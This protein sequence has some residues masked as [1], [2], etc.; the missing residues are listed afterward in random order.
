MT[1]TSPPKPPAVVMRDQLDTL[2]AQAQRADRVAS[3]MQQQLAALG[4]QLTVQGATP[5]PQAPRA[6]RLVGSGV[7]I[8][9]ALSAA[10]WGLL[11]RPQPIATVLLRQLDAVL[12][13]HYPTLP[14]RVQ[15]AVQTAYR[16]AGAP[17]P[18]QRQEH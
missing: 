1:E 6:W 4:Q 15:H 12:V 13:Q 16:Q 14:P 2:L 9:V 5:A 11:P 18:A 10:G 3:A 17:G 7:V 8:G